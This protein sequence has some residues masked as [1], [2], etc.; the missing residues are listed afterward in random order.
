LKGN[1]NRNNVELVTLCSIEEPNNKLITEAKL[2]ENSRA[3]ARGPSE[4][5]I[6]LQ[7]GGALTS[8][9]CYITLRSTNP[10]VL[11]STRTPY[12]YTRLKSI[13]L[14]QILPIKQVAPKQLL[15]ST[16]RFQIRQNRPEEVKKKFP[17]SIK[18]RIRHPQR[19]PFQRNEIRNQSRALT[20]RHGATH[21]PRLGFRSVPFQSARS[22]TRRLLGYGPDGRSRISVPGDRRAS[23]STA[24]RSSRARAAA[25]AVD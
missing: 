14:P 13:N 10:L 16:F 23:A 9:P 11:R 7:K 18:A 3:T 12:L 20:N 8:T 25:A 17:R 4:Q 21:P 1:G 24:A 2:T 5:H 19:V 6:S 15:D 22:V